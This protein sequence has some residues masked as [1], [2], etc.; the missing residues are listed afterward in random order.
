MGAAQSVPGEHTVKVRISSSYQ[1]PR[2]STAYSQTLQGY[3]TEME[4]HHIVSNLATVVAAAG[5]A[6]RPARRTFWFYTS[7]I[8]FI[9][10]LL[11]TTIMTPIG[12]AL[13]GWGAVCKAGVGLGALGVVSMIVWFV[14]GAMGVAAG[15]RWSA[16]AIQAVEAQFLPD[17]RARHPVMIFELR[18]LQQD[19]FELHVERMPE[20]RDSLGQVV[21]AG[22]AVDPPA[23]LVASAPTPDALRSGKSQS[24]GKGGLGAPLMHGYE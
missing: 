12:C 10:S 18:N 20:G 5:T 3:I 17:T 13:G 21:V 16:A 1:A 7:M 14:L 15:R 9:V 22:V 23:A 8:L 11:A 19:G 6:E 4:W 2:M 24:E